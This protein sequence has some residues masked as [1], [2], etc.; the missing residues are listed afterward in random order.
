MK[1]SVASRVASALKELFSKP[2][3]VVETEMSHF[4]TGSAY[5]LVAGIQRRSFC[6]IVPSPSPGLSAEASPD[7]S[8]EKLL[9]DLCVLSAEHSLEWRRNVLFQDRKSTRLNSSHSAKSRMPSSA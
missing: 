4:E 9:S 6:S 3:R 7:F 1:S 5:S 2:P 8:S